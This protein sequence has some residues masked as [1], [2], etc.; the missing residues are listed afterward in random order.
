MLTFKDPE[1]D[2]RRDPPQQSTHYIIKTPARAG[3]QQLAE[4]WVL[5]A[6]VRVGAGGGGDTIVLLPEEFIGFVG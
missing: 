2:V 1:V 4:D 5:G 6:C 3:S